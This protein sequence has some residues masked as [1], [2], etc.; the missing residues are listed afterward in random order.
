[1]ACGG[2]LVR[3]KLCDILGIDVP[4][5]QAPMGRTGMMTRLAAA[6]SNAGGL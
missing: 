4:I 5:L 6:V 2:H 1:M 3:T